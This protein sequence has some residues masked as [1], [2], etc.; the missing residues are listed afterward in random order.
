M[1]NEV[2]TGA[3]TGAQLGTALGGAFGPIGAAVGAGVGLAGGAIGGAIA[4]KRRKKILENLGLSQAEKDQM[5]QAAQRSAAQQVG[6]QQRAVARQTMATGGTPLAGRGAELTRQLTEA[7]AEAAQ[8]IEQARRAEYQRQLEG[9]RAYT[10]QAA[11]VIAP[12]VAGAM[13]TMLDRA[14][15]VQ[16]SPQTSMAQ[17][18]AGMTAGEISILGFM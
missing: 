15:V 4:Q 14:G 5:A 9:N 3:M 2:G 17:H 1:A 16:P 18:T 13:P 11:Q 8:Q 12:Q 6:A 7:G 10:A